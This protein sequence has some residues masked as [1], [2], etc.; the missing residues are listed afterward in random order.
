MCHCEL[1]RDYINLLTGGLRHRLAIGSEINS[2]HA[3]FSQKSRPQGTVP[4]VRQLQGVLQP[5]VSNE[6]IAAVTAVERKIMSHAQLVCQFW[7][8]IN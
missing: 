4:V 6:I 5:L 7:Q 1:H 3:E 2:H 8:D